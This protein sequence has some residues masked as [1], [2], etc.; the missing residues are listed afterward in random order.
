M[1]TSKNTPDVIV[2]EIKR[3]TRW[4]FNSEENIRIILEEL[5]GENSILEICRIEGIHHSQ[6]YRWSKEFLEAGKKR[7]N[8]D[9]VREA[10][11]PEVKDFREVNNALKQLVVE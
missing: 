1:A 11:S 3:K 6:Y 5:R 10:T 2:R 8:C 7:L 9:T 4:I